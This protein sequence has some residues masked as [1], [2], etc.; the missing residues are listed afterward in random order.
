MK[1]FSF[2]TLVVKPCHY[3][4]K[5]ASY[6]CDKMVPDGLEHKIFYRLYP[7]RLALLYGGKFGSD[8]EK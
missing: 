3:H 8:G 5:E 2:K 4:E 6:S 7:Y 1:E